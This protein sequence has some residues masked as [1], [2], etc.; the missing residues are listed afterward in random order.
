MTTS[1][2]QGK[3]AIVTGAGQGIGLEICSELAAQGASVVLNDVDQS[4]SD[5]AA[6]SVNGKCISYAGDASDY[7]FINRLVNHA[8]EKFGRLD[9]VIAN[10]GITL[11]GDFL[12]YKPEDLTSVLKLNLG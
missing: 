10:A 8:V 1:N 6:L 4:L 12:T 2:F 11:F 7:A 9:I 3:V 5:N